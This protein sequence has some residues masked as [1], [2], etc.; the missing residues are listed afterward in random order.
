V[1]LLVEPRQIGVV[2]VIVIDTRPVSA[3]PV[4]AATIWV[5]DVRTLT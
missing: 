4:R 1:T 2:F 5:A 3:T